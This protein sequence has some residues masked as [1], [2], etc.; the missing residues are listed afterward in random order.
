[1]TLREVA[2]RA[3]SG[4]IG[5]AG[6]AFVA[7]D[8]RLYGALSYHG[9]KVA[10]VLG[11]VALGAVLGSI[12]LRSVAWGALVALAVLWLAVALTPLDRALAD[13]MPRSDP[14]A[15]ADAVYVLASDVHP[16]GELS[17]DAQT[18]LLHGVELVRQ[19]LAPRLV[20]SELPPPDDHYADAARTLL[21]H[22]GIAA[23]LDAIGPV[24]T[25]H[26]E[27]VRVAEL[28]RARGWRRVILVT[29]PLHSRRAAAT[30]ERQGLEIASAP[31]S[32]PEYDLSLEDA[33]DRIRAFPDILHERLGWW[34]YARRGWL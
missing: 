17:V 2:R 12:K 20:V 31:A 14:L 23:D 19:G 27:A 10:I 15:R 5:A 4:A 22:L 26:D 13:G 28:A 25:T 29:S 1:M 21:G 33:D 8:L 7:K 11:V 32:E 3:T 18:R 6:A 34:V 24:Q 30:F 16:N 9:S